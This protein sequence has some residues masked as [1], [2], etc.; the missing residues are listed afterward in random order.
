MRPRRATKP[1]YVGDVKVGGDAPITVQS[2]TKTDT[3]DVQATVKQIRELEES[4][5]EI[6]RSAV[7]DME[8]A[9]AL[10]D[11]KKQITIPLIAHS[12]FHYQLGREA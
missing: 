3:R 8:A 1:L 5:C 10:A 4:G 12:H 7:P 9:V 6:V 11:I 2:M